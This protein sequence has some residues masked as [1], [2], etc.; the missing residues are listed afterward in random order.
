MDN[1][2]WHGWRTPEVFFLARQATAA[3]CLWWFPGVA[4]FGEAASRFRRYVSETGSDLADHS[5][6]PPP[7]AP[8]F[9]KRNEDGSDPQI[10]ADPHQLAWRTWIQ[11]AASEIQTVIHFQA[12]WTAHFL[13]GIHQKVQNGVHTLVGQGLQS[14]FLAY[15]VPQSHQVVLV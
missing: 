13:P 7:V 3:L 12:F 14:G 4:P 10:Q 5:G 6:F 8:G 11:V 1:A 15:F 9:P 2:A